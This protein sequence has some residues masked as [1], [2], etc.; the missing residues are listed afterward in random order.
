[1]SW[2]EVLIYRD[3]NDMTEMA[4]RESKYDIYS[5]APVRLPGERYIVGN[6]EGRSSPVF[7]DELLV[8]VCFPLMP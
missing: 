6:C 8:S 1:M 4:N 5:T 7:L 3:I 2:A